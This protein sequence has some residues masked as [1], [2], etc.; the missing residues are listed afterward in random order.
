[1]YHLTMQKEYQENLEQEANQFGFSETTH[2]GELVKNSFDDICFSHV[3]IGRDIA[4]YEN[5][6]EL[7]DG[8]KSKMR[9]GGRLVFTLS[10]PFSIDIISDILSLT[11]PTNQEKI[12][13]LC[14]EQVSKS[15]REAFTQVQI[16]NQ[17]NELDGIDFFIHQ[18]WPQYPKEQVK[19]LL[20]VDKYYYVCMC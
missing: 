2:I 18:H 17:V 16:V 8:I 7:L 1:M 13:F 10:N 12:C 3:F 6:Q 14:P 15:V 20:S 4:E 11:F 9:P 19:G 5:Y